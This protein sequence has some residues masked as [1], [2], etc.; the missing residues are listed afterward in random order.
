VTTFAYAMEI[1]CLERSSGTGTG[2]ASIAII[3]Y[4]QCTIDGSVRF[5]DPPLWI[6]SDHFWGPQFGGTPV[7]NQWLLRYSRVRF[8]EHIQGNQKMGDDGPAALLHVHARD[9]NGTR[10]SLQIFAAQFTDLNYHVGH[11]LGVLELSRE[12]YGLPEGV[13]LNTHNLNM[14]RQL[15]LNGSAIA[16]SKHCQPF[17]LALGSARRDP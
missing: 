16:K 5:C 13:D 8:Y 15:P 3:N 1:S 7:E 12:E 2:K 17:F 9:S 11:L 4:C 14:L 10:V 6:F